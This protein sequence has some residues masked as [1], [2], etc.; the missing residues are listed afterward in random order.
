MPE[1]KGNVTLAMK[2]MQNY[3]EPAGSH[4]AALFL[5]LQFKRCLLSSCQLNQSRSTSPAIRW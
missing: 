3:G 5:H 4:G 2:N 1:T